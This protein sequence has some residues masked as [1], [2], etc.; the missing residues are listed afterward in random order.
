MWVT[1]AWEI[2][3]RKFLGGSDVTSFSGVEWPGLR[4]FNIY[5]GKTAINI[6]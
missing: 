3:R 4:N 6:G 2:V 1:R 5:K